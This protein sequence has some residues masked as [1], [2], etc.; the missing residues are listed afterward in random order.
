M[1]QG[2]ASHHGAPHGLLS[3]LPRQLRPVVA[4]QLSL[5]S[6]AAPLGHPGFGGIHAE[7]APE[8]VGGPEKNGETYGKKSPTW[9]KS[10]EHL[11][12]KL[13]NYFR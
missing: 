12:E 11:L 9:G 8:G 2:Q 5:A 4:R 7:E 13:W 1:V 10:M 6:V 3:P